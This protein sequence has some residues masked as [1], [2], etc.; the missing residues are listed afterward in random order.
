MVVPLDSDG[1]IFIETKSSKM[2]C[3]NIGHQ[4]LPFPTTDLVRK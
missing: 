1:S 2:S 4:W 3:I